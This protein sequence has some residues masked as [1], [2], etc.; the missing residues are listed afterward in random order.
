MNDFFNQVGQMAIG[1]R[2]RL[3]ADRFND[4]AGKIYKAYGT[5]LQPKWFPVFFV[6]S[7]HTNQ[8][9]SFIAEEIKHS[10]VSVSKI[11]AEMMGAGLIT[12]KIDKN[13]GRRKLISLSKTGKEISEKIETQYADVTSAVR[14]INAEANHNL[15]SAIGDWENLLSEKSLAQRVLE[16][17]KERECG[18]VQIK[19]FSAKYKDAFR[20]LNKEWITTYFKMEKPDIEA[21]GDPK[22]YILDKGGFIFVALLD[23]EPV[24][25]C[26][27]IPKGKDVFEL[28]KMAV[29]SHVRGKK[30]GRRLGEVAIEKARLLKAKR[31]YL[32]SNTKLK[33]AVSLYRKLGF[34]EIT[35]QKTPYER[36]DIQM[37][38]EISY[39]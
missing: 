18:N 29:S 26:A 31:I 19:P 8:T 2:I 23:E 28:A 17:K 32:E 33:P 1:S 13:D 35:G 37:E 30:I 9:A 10:H 24:G 39:E 16:I 7:R 12:E 6:L 3:L 25:V 11:L 22:K 36:C 4:D 14:Q 27:L 38:L 15:W 34:I 20:D 21:L 5:E